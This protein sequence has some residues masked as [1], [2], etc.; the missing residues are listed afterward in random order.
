MASPALALQVKNSNSRILFSIIHQNG[1]ERA[2]T[3]HH[4]MAVCPIMYKRHFSQSAL[5]MADL[6]FDSSKSKFSLG[7]KVLAVHGPILIP[8]HVQ[9]QQCPLGRELPGSR[10]P[11][12][13]LDSR[14][15]LDFK[16][17]LPRALAPSE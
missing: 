5:Q 3:A 11:S 7:Q 8:A 1:V 6:I 16:W 15:I 17:P 10:S 9:G 14:E 2:W 13:L 12:C 4:A